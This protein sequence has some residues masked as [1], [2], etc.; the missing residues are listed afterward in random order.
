MDKY[1]YII[2]NF[3]AFNFNLNLS[4]FQDKKAC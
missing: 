3:F 1:V 2:E 4:L